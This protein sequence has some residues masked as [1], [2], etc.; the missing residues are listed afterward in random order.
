MRDNKKVEAF[1]KRDKRFKKMAKNASKNNLNVFTVVVDCC[2]EDVNSSGGRAFT[3]SSVKGAACITDWSG[4][5]RLL[6]KI[7]TK[8]VGFFFFPA[9]L[10]EPRSLIE[11][12]IK[13]RH[14]YY[15]QQV[16]ESKD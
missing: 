13:E 4:L 10:G 11:K 6:K 5:G 1:C 2:F 3:Y 14:E 15:K 12:V 8:M 16:Y 7:P 9:K